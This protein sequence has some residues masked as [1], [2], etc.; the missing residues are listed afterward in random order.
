MKK[1][2]GGQK[3]TWIKTIK[4]DLELASININLAQP[5]EVIEK[6]TNLAANRKEWSSIVR[7]V[8]SGTPYSATDGQPSGCQ[9][10]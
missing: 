4:R 3:N 1:K 5:T 6:L 9:T 7:H 2:K 10:Y 8:M